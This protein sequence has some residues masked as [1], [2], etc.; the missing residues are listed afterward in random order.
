[1]QASGGVAS[2]RSTDFGL[3]HDLAE[4]G[5]DP[6][7]GVDLGGVRI[8]RLVGEGGMGRVYAATQTHP[9]RTVAVKVMRTPATGAAALKR[10]RREADALARLRHPGIAQI[11][12]A[13]CHRHG[14]ADVPFYVMEFIPGAEPLVAACER[15]RLSIRRR[16]EL[17]LNVCEAVG[18]GHAA[19]IVHRDIKPGNVLVDAAGHPKIIDFGIARMDGAEG[20]APQTETGQFIGTRPYMAP[21]QFADH[22]TVIDARTDVHAIGVLM[23]EVLTGRLPY[24]VAGK[25]LVETARIV[26]RARP[27]RLAVAG[28]VHA[29]RLLL[30]GAEAIAARC[31]AKEPAARYATADAVAAD[32]RRLLA[33][34]RVGAGQVEA[35]GLLGRAVAFATSRSTVLAGAALMACAAALCAAVFRAPVPAAS[36]R[37]SPSGQA[38]VPVVVDGMKRAVPGNGLRTVAARFATVSSGRT[39]PLE[40]V[41]LDFED[42]V[43]GLAPEDFRLTRNG[44]PIGIAGLN[45]TGGPRSW[46][47]GG[48]GSLT[49][50]A[51]EYLLAAVGTAVS[52]VDGDGTRVGISGQ[53]RWR[54]PPYREI[55]FGLFDDDWR[56]HVVSLVDAE[57]YT[58]R[59]AGATTFIRPTVAGREGRI[60]LRFDLPF[61]IQDA[62]LTA[63]LA[64]W[65]TGDPFPY[66]PGARA[67]LEVSPD[68]ETWKPVVELEAGAGGTNAATHEIGPLV[69]GG[70]SIW[71]RVRLTATKEWPGDGLIFAQFLRT[72]PQDKATRF[73]L[74]ATGPHPP[75]IPP[76]GQ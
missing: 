25:S 7:L 61:T 48:L 71:V 67:T 64:V 72:D 11:F 5:P 21:E 74:T 32:L 45:V 68:G 75:V 18:H 62:T 35:G 16:L 4:P 28:V 31:L 1:T 8:D 24:D 43:S 19:G 14:I 9:A 58:E 66:D 41:N 3:G 52:P 6:L 46:R 27:A 55:Q 15:R 63:P 42:D 47:V 69:T 59:Q 54:S 29:D 60:I 26:Q 44:G 12:T 20:D 50:E 56:R 51:G 23:H 70:T 17:L 22:R 37:Q 49:A 73:R 53:V 33:G 40:W 36:G 57:R 30:R 34:E 2:Q 13:G 65:T 10:F 38:D 76:T 39:T